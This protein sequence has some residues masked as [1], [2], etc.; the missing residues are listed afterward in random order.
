VIEAR[1]ADRDQGRLDD[2]AAELVRLNPDV[3]VCQATPSS[4]AARKATA[5]IPIVAVSI[6]DPVGSGLVASLAHPGGNVT[7]LGLTPPEIGAK[8]LQML[9][10]LTPT[11]TRIAI[12]WNPDNPN[13]ASTLTVT[14]Q[15]ARDPSLDLALVPLPVKSVGDFAPAFQQALDQRADGV[16]FMASALSGCCMPQIVDFTTRNHLPAMFESRISGPD[17]GGL[18]SYAPSSIEN[19]RRAATLVDKILKGANP[20]DLPVEQPSTFEYVINLKA[21]QSIGLTF[22]QSLLAQATELIQ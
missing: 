5:R 15:A 17:A 21:A 12:F 2:L 13:D 10:E 9:K 20:A 19:Y 1:W 6:S 4:I 18:M 11:T 8:R 16:V 7:G 3:I 14:E 22:P